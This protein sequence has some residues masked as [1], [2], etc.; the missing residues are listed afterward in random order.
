MDGGNRKGLSKLL[1]GREPTER[2]YEMRKRILARLT[3]LD[4]LDGITQREERDLRAARRWE[5]EDLNR[6][7]ERDSKRFWAHGDPRLN[8]HKTLQR[9]VH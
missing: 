5:V 4:G 8:S 3:L 1:D 2:A 9:R 7:L 6:E